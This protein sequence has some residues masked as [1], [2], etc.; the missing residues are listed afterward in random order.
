MRLEEFLLERGMTESGAALAAHAESGNG[1][2]LSCFGFSS[3]PSF[4]FGRRLI[5]R[6]VRAAGCRFRPFLR[7]IE[8]QPA[9]G[10]YSRS[11][12]ALRPP[13]GVGVGSPLRLVIA[14]RL[15]L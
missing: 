10:S 5:A 11:R 6:F 8:I 9:R 3:R 2:K 1:L 15:K 12:S 4:T 7:L 13:G 14:P